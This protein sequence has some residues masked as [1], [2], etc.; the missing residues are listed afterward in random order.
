MSEYRYCLALHL[1][2]MDTDPDR[3]VLDAD[4]DPNPINDADPTGSGSTAMF[5]IQCCGTGIE[6]VGTNCFD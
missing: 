2:E 5:T 6:T 4:P 1:V 3:P